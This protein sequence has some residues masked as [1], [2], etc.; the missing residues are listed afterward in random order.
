MDDNFLC[1]VEKFSL[2]IQGLVIGEG[3]SKV[4]LLENSFLLHTVFGL[5]FPDSLNDRKENIISQLTRFPAL[6]EGDVI[7]WSSYDRTITKIQK[8]TAS[9]IILEIYALFVELDWYR[10]DAK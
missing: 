6:V 1:L 8:A 4:R 5:N 2:L 10:N 3:N 7:I 9:R